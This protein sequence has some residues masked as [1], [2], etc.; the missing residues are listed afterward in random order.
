MKYFSILSVILAILFASGCQQ[1]QQSPAASAGVEKK[2][3]LMAA[4]MMNLK[5]ELQKT[6]LELDKQTKSLQ[7]LNLKNEQII[8]KSA[9]DANQLNAAVTSYSKCYK[10]LNDVKKQLEECQKMVDLTDVPALCKDKVEKQ[11]KLLA[12]C[13]KEK[14]ELE[15]SAGEASDFALK[16]LPEELMKQVTDLTAEN[17]QLKAKIAELEKAAAPK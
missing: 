2:E 5:A 12:E 9:Q 17:E 13:Q 8:R 3:K 4:E 11:N 10:E 14:E 15:K 16:Q 7:E 6:K 1:S